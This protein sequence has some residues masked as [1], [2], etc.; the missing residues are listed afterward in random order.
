MLAVWARFDGA[1]SFNL[2][3]LSFL[4]NVTGRTDCDPVGSGSGGTGTIMAAGFHVLPAAERH[5]HPPLK[6]ALR[7]KVGRF[8]ELPD[9]VQFRWDDGRH[10]W[11]WQPD[12][13]HHG[14]FTL[15]PFQ[16][17]LLLHSSVSEPEIVPAHGSPQRR[18]L[19]LTFEVTA[20]PGKGGRRER[21]GFVLDVSE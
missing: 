21:E 12:Q 14:T 5:E 10:G 9:A 17:S 11:V 2:Q 18:P 4:G 19:R 7:N 13:P 20:R 8:A 1:T 16:G 3:T 6:G 15:L